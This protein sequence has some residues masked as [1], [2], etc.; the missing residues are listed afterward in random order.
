VERRA[1]KGELG[2]RSE[3]GRT[4]PKDELDTAMLFA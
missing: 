4:L 2:L 1:K 3:G